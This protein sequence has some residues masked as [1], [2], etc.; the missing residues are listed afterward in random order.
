MFEEIKL[1][2]FKKFNG[3]VLQLISIGSI[4]AESRPNYSDMDVIA[5]VE[6][7]MQSYNF[8]KEVSGLVLDLSLK[9]EVFISIYPVGVS[10]FE[11]STSQFIKNIKTKGQIL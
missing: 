11:S 2:I 3:S 8:L 7:Q 1:S 10:I 4:L 9:Y 5:V 6:D